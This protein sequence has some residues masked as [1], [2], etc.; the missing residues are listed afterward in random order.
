VVLIWWS[1]SMTKSA[2]LKEEYRIK[3]LSRAEKLELCSRKPV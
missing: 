2:A 3:Q 1:L